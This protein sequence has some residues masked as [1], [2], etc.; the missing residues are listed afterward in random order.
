MAGTYKTPIVRTIVCQRIQLKTK[1]DDEASGE[2]DHTENQ[3][4][5]TAGTLS[6]SAVSPERLAHESLAAPSVVKFR[7]ALPIISQANT[8][9]WNKDHLASV[10]SLLKIPILRASSNSLQL[11]IKCIIEGGIVTASRNA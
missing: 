3:T 4:T 11:L 10:S 6:S 2:N 8:Y 9:L 5:P 1:D 7:D